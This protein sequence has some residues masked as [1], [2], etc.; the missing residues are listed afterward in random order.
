M[1]FTSTHDI[2]RAIT[3]FGKKKFDSY[4]LFST[5]DSK[6]QDMIYECFWEM[7]Y[8]NDDIC[9]YLQGSREMDYYLYQSFMNHLRE[10][11]VSSDMIDYLKNI[12]SYSPF[13][14]YQVWAKD[15]PHAIK[16]NLEETKNYH[17]T[18]EEYEEAKK[19]YEAYL[20]FLAAYPGIL[21]IFYGD[22]AGMEGLNNL[23]NRRPF[24]WN[25][26][27][28][29]LVQMV[30]MIG[31]FRKK[32]PFLKTAD[33]QLLELNP[34]YVSFERKLGKEQMLVSINN[35]EEERKLLLPKEYK[36]GEKILTLKKSKKDFLP[37][38]GGVII[39]R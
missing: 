11:K 8:T 27:D 6:V 2:S 3:L 9:A 14:P 37:P 31:Q 35:S 26:E 17:L 13:D 4:H 34:T 25:H 38:Y 32:Y 24:P 39:M 21:S 22:E 23:V 10:K 12:L 16:N 33:F 5:L 36:K 15:I 29:E 7:G 20:F 18:K 30:R 28:L 1:N 19:V